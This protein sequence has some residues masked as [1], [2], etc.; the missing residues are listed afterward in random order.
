VSRYSP[1]ALDFDTL[2]FVARAG[3]YLSSN[4]RRGRRLLSGARSL[5][6]CRGDLHQPAPVALLDTAPT[7]CWATP[8]TRPTALS[9]G[10]Y[11]GDYRGCT[12]LSLAVRYLSQAIMAGA[13]AA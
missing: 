4:A 3:G 6:A 9:L 2:S 11:N 8:A 12:R 10:F 13:G 7:G 5:S 1:T